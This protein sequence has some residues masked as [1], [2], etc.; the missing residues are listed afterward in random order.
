MAIV[1]MHYTVYTPYKVTFTQSGHLITY[2]L[3]QQSTSLVFA[4]CS[5]IL[6]IFY[7]APYHTALH[8]VYQILAF[9]LCSLFFS[10]Q[11]SLTRNMT[12]WSSFSPISFPFSLS[13]PPLTVSP[14]PFPSSLSTL[15]FHSPVAPLLLRHAP[16]PSNI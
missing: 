1:G 14:L 15:P 3:T 6:R 4:Q 7:L 8:P 13:L 11:C 12:K 10:T 16:L 5:H 9:S 2:F